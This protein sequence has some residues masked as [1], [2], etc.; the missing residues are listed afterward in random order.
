MVLRRTH[1]FA[2][3]LGLLLFVLLA[4]TGLALNHADTLGLAQARVDAPLLLRWYGR[5]A[6][7]IGP[8][9]A[10]SDQWLSRVGERLYLDA[11]PLDAEADRLLGAVAS[12]DLS[13]AAA[14]T[15]LWLFTA[16]GELVEHQVD[17]P[18][19]GLRRIGVDANGRVVVAASGGTQRADRDLLSWSD[20]QGTVNWSHA[21]P[22]PGP[23]TQV[24]HQA[25]DGEGPTWERLL[26]DLHSGRLFGVPGWLPGWLLADLAGVLML[27][28]S[29]SGLWTWLRQHRLLTH[30]RRRHAGQHHFPPGKG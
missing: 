24:L 22:L 1:R 17:G 20:Y 15:G 18:A 30:H 8:G 5:Q 23:L 6:D 19:L 3:L 27:L 2:G 7:A 13:V 12:G 29:G 25:H 4:V 21:R 11:Q 10:V 9:Y 14:D 28:L 16:D 26:L